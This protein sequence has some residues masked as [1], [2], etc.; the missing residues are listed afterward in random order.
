MTSFISLLLP[1]KIN[2]ALRDLSIAGAYL[3]ESIDESDS[4]RALFSSDITL[5]KEELAVPVVDPSYNQNILSGL[6]IS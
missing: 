3:S 4:R 2:F 5:F 1:F 6:D